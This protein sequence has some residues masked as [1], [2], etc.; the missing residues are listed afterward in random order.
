[1]LYISKDLLSFGS[2]CIKSEPVPCKADTWAAPDIKIE[3][4]IVCS[5]VNIFEPVVANEP[6]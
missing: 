2:G 1:V 5:P 6:V 4:V 3:P